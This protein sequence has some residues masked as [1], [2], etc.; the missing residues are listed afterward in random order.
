MT[1]TAAIIAIS[2]GKI[3]DEPSITDISNAAS[4]HVL[5]ISSNGDLLLNES[6]GEF[7]FETWE[8]VVDR[9]QAVCQGEDVS[10]G[11]KDVEMDGDSEGG[12]EDGLEGFVRE[13]VGDKIQHDH[14]WSI[15]T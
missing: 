10:L 12:Q 15:A 8:T 14:A 9:A 11:D 3:L 13:V 4:L 1:Y 6:E 5:A 7:D 2:S